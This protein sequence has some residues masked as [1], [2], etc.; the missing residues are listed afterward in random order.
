MSLSCSRRRC[1]RAPALGDIKSD[2]HTRT[3]ANCQSADVAHQTTGSVMRDPQTAGRPR[4]IAHISALKSLW[5]R[6]LLVIS[7]CSL[8]GSSCGFF[9]TAR[10]NNAR[11]FV[12]RGTRPRQSSLNCS[13]RPYGSGPWPRSI[14]VPGLRHP[15]RGASGSATRNTARLR[16]RVS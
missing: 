8:A 3:L 6:G 13:S 12:V 1:V 7:D 14:P 11:G 16:P 4:K 9:S 2:P 15:E 10:C 5:R